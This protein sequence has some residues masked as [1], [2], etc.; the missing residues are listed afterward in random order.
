MATPNNSRPLDSLPAVVLL[1]LADAVG[2]LSPVY[3]PP[4]QNDINNLSATSRT[5]RTICERLRLRGLLINFEELSPMGRLD[6]LF[7]R[8]VNQAY[9]IMQGFP[10]DIHWTRSF[11]LTTPAVPSNAAWRHYAQMMQRAG[12][13]LNHVLLNAPRLRKLTVVIPTV[14]HD[15]QDSIGIHGGVR[16]SF[17]EELVIDTRSMFLFDHC[18]NIRRLTL[19][20][21]ISRPDRAGSELRDLLVRA[22]NLPNLRVLDVNTADTTMM[23]DFPP[24]DRIERL[25]IVGVLRGNTRTEL[26]QLVSTLPTLMPNLRTMALVVTGPRHGS[27]AAWR[28]FQRRTVA[29]NWIQQFFDNHNNLEEFRVACITHAPAVYW[30]V[31]PPTLLSCWRARRPQSMATQP[32]VLEEQGEIDLG[33]FSYVDWRPSIHLCISAS[34]AALHRYIDFK[35]PLA[36]HRLGRQRTQTLTGRLGQRESKKRLGRWKME[37]AR[38][39]QTWMASTRGTRREQRFWKPVPVCLASGASSSYIDRPPPCYSPKTPPFSLKVSSGLIKLSLM[40]VSGVICFFYE[41]FRRQYNHDPLL[42]P[43]RLSL[44]PRASRNLVTPDHAGFDRTPGTPRAGSR[45]CSL[46]APGL[47]MRASFRVAP[48]LET[49]PTELL[50][51]IVRH[52]GAFAPIYHKPGTSSLIKLSNTNKRMRDMCHRLKLRGLVVDMNDLS[53]ALKC[54]N[55]TKTRPDLDRPVF[56]RAANFLFH[57]VS[58]AGGLKKLSMVSPQTPSWYNFGGPSA[59]QGLPELPFVE[60]LIIDWVSRF[61]TCQDGQHRDASVG[62]SASVGRQNRLG[63]C[64]CPENSKPPAAGTGANDPKLR[65]DLAQQMPNLISLTLLITGRPSPADPAVMVCNRQILRR[66]LRSK[67]RTYGADVPSALA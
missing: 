21:F 18:P 65:N 44:P 13:I 30:H 47:L 34:Q 62:R 37:N 12:I 14:Q 55:C 48:T 40:N 16:F 15:W 32:F 31:N 46:S 7:S 1:H 8:P 57:V 19:T 54:H 61:L 36:L 39:S 43:R 22:S 45:L 23:S 3:G 35:A 41:T 10:Q 9:E 26:L 28:A 5:M 52:V 29:R 51:E 64:E 24:M 38:Y 25:T 60:N 2:A 17:V 50:L 42:C 49:L 33:A 67:R 53:F 59:P 56:D 4:G 27:I 66:V 6:S 63:S 20:S 11:A 58:V